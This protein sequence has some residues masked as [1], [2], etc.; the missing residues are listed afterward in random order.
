VVDHPLAQRLLRELSRYRLR[1]ST[2]A[3]LQS[4]IE[5]ALVEIGDEYNRE[6]ALSAK[7]RPDF[8]VADVAI[9]AKARYNKRGIYRQLERYAEHDA[10]GAII[11]VTN[12]AL[13]MPE[14]I[15]NKPI[16]VLPTGYAFL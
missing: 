15:K 11:L 13:G 3:A 1:V 7:D 6:Y 8:M 12:T 5:A 2:E 16:Y 9:E 14:Y 10:V 4:S